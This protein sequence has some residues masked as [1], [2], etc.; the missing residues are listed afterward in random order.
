[1]IGISYLAI[2][3]STERDKC[4]P[5]TITVPDPGDDR[6]VIEAT[7]K[8]LLDQGDK[9]E[10]EIP[11]INHI[12]VANNDS[13]EGYPVIINQVKLENY[14]DDKDNDECLNCGSTDGFNMVPKC[15][16]C[17]YINGE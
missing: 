17:G 15:N 10:I 11:D 2:V 12:L 14:Y 16:H 8:A 13:E 3:V 4:F 6:Q 9:A 1:M 5:I 7:Y